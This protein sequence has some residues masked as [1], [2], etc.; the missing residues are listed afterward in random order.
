MGS[1]QIARMAGIYCPRTPNVP[2][3]RLKRRNGY[4][5]VTSR[6]RNS[7]TAPEVGC[8][9][10]T[11]TVSVSLSGAVGATVVTIPSGT[12]VPREVLRFGV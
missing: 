9:E 10:R 7:R 4:G 5:F 12:Q 11:V 3:G 2:A 8:V 6:R 1:V